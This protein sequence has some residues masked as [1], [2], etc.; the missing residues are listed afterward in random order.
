M[1]STILELLG[2]MMLTAAVGL[3]FGPAG[4]LFA[5]GVCCLVLAWAISRAS[6]RST[7]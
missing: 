2:M 4:A 3:T 5:A 7:S 6:S 1:L